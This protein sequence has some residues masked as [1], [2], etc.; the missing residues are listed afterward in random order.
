MKNFSLHLG[1]KVHLKLEEGTMFMSKEK[2]YLVG[3]NEK[4][5]RKSFFKSMNIIETIT[6]TSCF[7]INSHKFL[8][9]NES[10]KK[11]K[12]HISFFKCKQSY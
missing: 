1:P 9:G 5:K 12:Q 3:D 7:N 4:R 6:N 10:H 2:N 8:Q 11:L